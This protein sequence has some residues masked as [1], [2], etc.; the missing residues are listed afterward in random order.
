MKKKEREKVKIDMGCCVIKRN[1]FT[2]E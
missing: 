2:G 1:F